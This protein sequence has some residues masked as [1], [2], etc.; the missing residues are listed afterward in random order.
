[1]TKTF[2]FNVS[3]VPTIKLDNVYCDVEFQQ[4]SGNQVQVVLQ[5]DADDE[6]NFSVNQQGNHTV[7]VKQEGGGLILVVVEQGK[8]M[9]KI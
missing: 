1:M 6:R 3:G 2:N 4:S 8:I 9:K 7:V 5:A